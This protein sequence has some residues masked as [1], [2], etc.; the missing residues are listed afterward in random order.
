M[1][2]ENLLEPNNN[3]AL[4]NNGPAD[5]TTGLWVFGYGSLCWQPGFDYQNEMTGYVRGYARKFWQGNTTHRGTEKKPGR[6][7]TLVEEPDSIVWGRAYEVKG[8][9]ALPYLNTRECRLGG[10]LTQFATFYP[11]SSSMKPFPTL[12]YVATP[13]NNLWLG[14]APLTE[15]ATQISECRG[16]SGHNVEYLIRLATF[17]RDTIPEA[18]D[19]HLFTLEYLVRARIKEMNLNLDTLMGNLPQRRASQ[20]NNRNNRPD[21]GAVGGAVAPPQIPPPVDTFQ[22]TAHVP[23]KQLRCLNM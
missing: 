2:L 11:R 15:I 20:D 16:S 22:F 14:D 23:E 18:I 4:N 21:D 1:D 7:A 19:E 3:E 17:M 10:Y 6:V 9:A 13:N 5:E 12:L 8:D